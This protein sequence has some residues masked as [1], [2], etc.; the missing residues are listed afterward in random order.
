MSRRLV[1]PPLES[2]LDWLFAQ[3]TSGRTS[4]DPLAAIARSLGSPH[5]DFA[6]V[7][8]AGTNGKGSVATKVARTLQLAGV[9]AGLFTSPHV[10]QFGERIQVDQVAIDPKDIS[11]GLAQ[12]RASCPMVESLNF[13]DIAFL[14]AICH[15]RRQGVEFAI[16]EAGIGGR[17]DATNIC[18][19]RVSAITTIGLDHCQILGKTLPEIA[20]EKGGIVKFNTPLI[21]GARAAGHGIEALARERSAPLTLAG[22]RHQLFESYNRSVARA[23]LGAL[24]RGFALSPEVLE[25]GLSHRPPCRYQIARSSLSGFATNRPQTFILDVAHNPE[26]FCELARQIEWDFPGY[27]LLIVLGLGIDKDLRG[28]LSALAT[29]PIHKIIPCTLP[30]IS[31]HSVV[32]IARIAR[33]LELSVLEEVCD[34]SPASAT[35]RACE[36][37]TARSVTVICGSFFMMKEVLT[38][39]GA[40]DQPPKRPLY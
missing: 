33:K 39:L 37:A 8:I 31:S 25:E 16:L 21:L 24:D 22:E 15:F 29:L 13:F 10:C 2:A 36:L 5:L 34:Y 7:H 18:R 23:V 17:L 35:K 40:R 28:C 1:L 30:T 38:A 4:L 12:L 19:P 32:E 27:L 3:K 26:G 14:L 11:C 9:R 6:T 20:R